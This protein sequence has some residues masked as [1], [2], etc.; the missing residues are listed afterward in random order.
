MVGSLRWSWRELHGNLCFDW[1]WYRRGYPFFYGEDSF[2]SDCDGAEFIDEIMS[3]NFSLRIF[4]D[5]PF[6]R[7]SMK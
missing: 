7:S 3:G 6:G 5:G 4:P 1:L 2:F